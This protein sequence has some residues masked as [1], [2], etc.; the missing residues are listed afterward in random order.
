[1]PLNVEPVPLKQLLQ[2]YG[3]G[4]SDTVIMKTLDVDG[5]VTMEIPPEHQDPLHGKSDIDG[6]KMQKDLKKILEESKAVTVTG[7]KGTSS[8]GAK[9]GKI[10]WKR[11]FVPPSIP[12]GV[13]ANGYKEKNGELLPRGMPQKKNEVRSIL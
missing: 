5:L 9:T 2:T 12:S 8:K 1:M 4:P 6:K 7:G 13:M 11:K 3:T 10:V